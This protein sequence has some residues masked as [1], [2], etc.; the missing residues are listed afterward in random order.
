MKTIYLH[1]GIGKT[2]TTTIQKYFGKYH[3]TFLADNIRYVNC[4]G[5]SEGHG[6]QKFAKSFITNLP[7]MMQPVD[8]SKET[9]DSVMDEILTSNENNILISSEN[10]QLADPSRVKLF[11]ESLGHKFNYKIILFV[12][13]QDELAESEYNQ[14]MKVRQEKSCFDEYTKN[15]FVGNFYYLANNWSSIFGLQNIICKIFN[16]GENNVIKDFLGCLPINSEVEDFCNLQI[17]E[18]DNQSIGFA[19]LQIKKLLNRLQ[20]E[21]FKDEHIELPVSI[22]NLFKDIDIP[23]VLMDAFSA[24]KFRKK[25]YRSNMQFSKKFLGVKLKD[26]GGRRYSD[27]QRNNLFK[28]CKDLLR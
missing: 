5:G 4:S 10:F 16:A 21:R 12:R 7:S 2:G 3:K 22:N 19:Q 20:A 9:L 23:P 6:H 18:L 15:N 8:N 13:S 24:K 1:I 26:L 11:F 27:D 28:S 25:F 17:Q 14:I